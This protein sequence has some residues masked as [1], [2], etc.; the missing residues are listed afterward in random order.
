MPYNN[1]IAH[2]HYI[3][4]RDIKDVCKL[5]YKKGLSKNLFRKKVYQKT[6]LERRFIKKPF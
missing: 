4:A 6:F 3:Y 5:F 2:G 1:D